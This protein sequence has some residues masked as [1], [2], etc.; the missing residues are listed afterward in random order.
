MI[1]ATIALLTLIISVS[2]IAESLGFMYVMIEEAYTDR[3][4]R[5]ADLTDVFIFGA[6]GV[7]F[8]VISFLILDWGAV[9]DY[10]IKLG[11]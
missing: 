8:G 7:L 9:I 5:T 10:A 6:I 3:R 2:S 11:G 1:R 4:V